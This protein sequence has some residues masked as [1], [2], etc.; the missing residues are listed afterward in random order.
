MEIIDFELRGLISKIIEQAINRKNTVDTVRWATEVDTI[1]L[2]GKT[3][4]EDFT[5][6][7]VVGSLMRE[8]I[9][10]IYWM[11]WARKVDAQRERR[12]VKILG[13]EKYNELKAKYSKGRGGRPI[14]VKVTESEINE[15]KSMIEPLI[16][17]FRSKI[18]LEWTE[19]MFGEHK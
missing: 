3:R 7:Y 13:R 18:S 4:L 14:K 1:Q 2:G 5:L 16:E 10:T 19:L 8:A 6:G 9:E 15:I 12:N 17:Q 11:K